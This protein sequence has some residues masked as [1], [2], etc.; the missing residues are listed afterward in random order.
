LFMLQ[1]DANNSY[2]SKHEPRRPEANV[3][4]KKLM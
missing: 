2:V 1:H 3:S 4:S